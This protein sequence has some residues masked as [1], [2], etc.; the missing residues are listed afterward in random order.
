M[1]GIRY[2]NFREGDRSEYLANY[3]LSGI[4]LV[5]PFPRQEDIGID[6]YCSLADQER[7]SLTFGF[8][9]LVQVKSSSETE[10]SFGSVKEGKWRH[11]DIQWLFRQELPLFIGFVDKSAPRLDL[12]NTSAFWFTVM[13]HPNCSQIVFK[14]RR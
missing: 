5:I 4:G 14:P 6:F 3:L 11:E 2:Y 1:S 8:P 10:L 13:A 7:G 12:F 9:Y